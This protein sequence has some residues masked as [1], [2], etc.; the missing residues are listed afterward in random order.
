MPYLLL[1]IISSLK[2]AVSAV[3]SFVSR[4]CQTLTLLTSLITAGQYQSR[5]F[6]KH[7][8]ME[9]LKEEDGESRGCQ[10]FAPLN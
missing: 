8:P 9:P 5:L 10:L 4:L 2:T 1:S 3:S 7:F 6:S